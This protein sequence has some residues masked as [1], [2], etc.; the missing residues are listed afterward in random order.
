MSLNGRGK[1]QG[2]THFGVWMG[3]LNGRRFWSFIL[4]LPPLEPDRSDTNVHGVFK[5]YQVDRL[6]KCVEY[7]QYTKDVEYVQYVNFIYILL[8]FCIFLY[9]LHN[10]H[11]R[12]INILVY[13]TRHCSTH[14]V[15]RNP[16]PRG[17]TLSCIPPCKTGQIINSEAHFLLADDTKEIAADQPP[18]LGVYPPAWNLRRRFSAPNW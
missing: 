11:I 3:D 6:F 1:D 13:R 8:N 14:C 15:Y 5:L 16:A 9:I 4:D 18:G 7:V 2:F 12:H 10:R 17:G